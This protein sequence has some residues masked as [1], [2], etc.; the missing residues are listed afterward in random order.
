MTALDL[1]DRR[2]E[3]RAARRW[4]HLADLDPLL[5]VAA[6]GL[7][8]LGLVLVWSA[9]AA[10]LA[11]DGADPTTAV[12]RQG[13]SL[14]IGLLLAYGA[15]RT[16]YP[17]LRVVAPWAFL[18]GVIMLGLT[19]TPLGTSLA[20]AR[21]WLQLPGGFTLQPSEF[22]KIALILLLAT[23]GSAVV[24]GALP[25][26]MIV[27]SLAIAAVPLALVL[28]QNDAGTMLVMAAVAF[29]M[30]VIAGAPVRWVVGLLAATCAGA[31]AV[32]QFGL[33]QEY[34]MAR[35]TTFLSPDAD[36]LATGYNALQARIAISGGGILGQGL[37]AG[38]QTQG[39]FVPVNESDFIFSVV[40]EEL[41]LVGAALLI[42]LLGIVLWRGLVIAVQADDLFGRLVAVGIVAW[43]AFQAFENI[44]M[45]LGI[46]PVTGVTLPFV[47][48]GGTSIMATWV[49][50]GILQALHVRRRQGVLVRPG[51]RLRGG[52][53]PVA[54]GSAVG[55]RPAH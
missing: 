1:A 25:G 15:S 22:M 8:V 34:Q 4:R 32:V 18:L 30:I 19:L 11:A 24:M 55:V 40:G 14:L 10:D 7:S 35:L 13:L 26:G 28:V 2:R 3:A 41:G 47:S 44:G 17:M 6:L 51:G 54:A 53:T 39:S 33:L 49:A 37:F 9:S 36:G 23:V 27:R 21:A 31:A 48:Y 16:A 45:N 52:T 46:M 42:G 5:L 12:K 43:F 20:G 38:S 29:T 50:V